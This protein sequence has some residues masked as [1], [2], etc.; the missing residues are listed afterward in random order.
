MTELQKVKK[1]LADLQSV[2]SHLRGQ[3]N[4]Y[5]DKYG[6][7]QD[8]LKKSRSIYEG[9]QEDMKKVYAWRFCKA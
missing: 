8:S 9:Y 3:V 7:F 4:M 6:E 1:Q 5:S 2:E